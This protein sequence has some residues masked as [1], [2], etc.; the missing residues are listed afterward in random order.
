M[1]IMKIKSI[2]PYTGRYTAIQLVTLFIE[3]PVWSWGDFFE[4]AYFNNFHTNGKK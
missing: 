2:L 4:S 1:L 3:I